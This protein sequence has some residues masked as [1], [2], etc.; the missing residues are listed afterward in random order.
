MDVARIT[1][2]RLEDTIMKGADVN[3]LP[4]AAVRII[5]HLLPDR[6]IKV[7]RAI[8]SNS[9]AVLTV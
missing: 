4:T 9:V 1:K 2:L 5:I 7:V 8:H 6:A 3:T